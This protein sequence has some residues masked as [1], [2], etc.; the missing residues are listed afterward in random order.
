MSMKVVTAKDAKNTFGELLET[1]QREP[2]VVTKHDRPVSVM[3]SVNDFDAMAAF[4]EQMKTTIHA[5]IMAGI[6]DSEAG[7]TTEVNDTFIADMQ[8]ELAV[9]LSNKND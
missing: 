1:S 3:F 4:V 9:R 6:A 2:V 5:G 8:A 7:R